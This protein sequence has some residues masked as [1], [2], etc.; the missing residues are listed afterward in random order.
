MNY[1]EF[2]GITA[3]A[4]ESE[5][6]RAY[7]KLALK[8]HP[9]KNPNSNEAHEK[10]QLLGK[11]YSVLRDPVKREDYNRFGEASD[12]EEDRRF[13][14]AEEGEE[15]EEQNWSYEEMAKV[16][17]TMNVVLSEKRFNEMISS[18]E[19]EQKIISKNRNWT[20]PI[21]LEGVDK[22]AKA[23]VSILDWSKRIIHSLPET[24]SQLINITTFILDGNQLIHLPKEI[25]NWKKIKRLEIR[26]NQLTSL[27]EEIGELTELELL[28][29]EH[30]NLKQ[31]PSSIRNLKK[32][33]Q[34]V[35]FA[36][37]LETVPEEL[38]ELQHLKL[39]DLDCNFLQ[40][41][42]DSVLKMKGVELRIDE[43]FKH[44]SSN[45]GYKALN[46]KGKTEKKTATV[47][48]QK[49]RRTVN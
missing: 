42:P 44:A 46:A 45:Q 17:N 48:K 27:P 6:K 34:L 47:P 32:L 31:I 19:Y 23:Q 18:I 7:Y 21:V 24:V 40:A 10:F 28:N 3:D 5:I 26:A 9:D 33:T 43:S 25:K 35:L 36:N 22:A 15:V 4:N 13:E 49:K 8:Y 12:D 1:Y 29:L 14:E 11:I 30:N 2:L 16:F 20:N 41:V 39:L 38:S 37:K